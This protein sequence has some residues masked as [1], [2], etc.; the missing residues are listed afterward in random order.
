[1]QSKFL[2][3]VCPNFANEVA[4]PA[5]L[6]KQSRSFSHGQAVSLV[7]AAVH[8]AL[9][10]CCSKRQVFTTTPGADGLARPVSD[11]PLV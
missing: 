2:G 11:K 10:S 3:A 7:Y 9:A 6:L 8:G 4:T 5:G 1:M